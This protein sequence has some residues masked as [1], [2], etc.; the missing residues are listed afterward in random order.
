MAFRALREL[1][2]PYD[3]VLENVPAGSHTVSVT[4]FGQRCNSFTPVH[5]VNL[6]HRHMDPGAWRSK[7]DDWSYEYNLLPVGI[8]KAPEVT[9]LE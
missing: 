2:T 3:A 6:H 7:G 1:M 5:R 8:L 9:V 4:L